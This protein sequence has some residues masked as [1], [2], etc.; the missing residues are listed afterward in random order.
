MP[1]IAIVRK[2]KCSGPVGNFVRNVLHMPSSKR[3]Q[4]ERISQFAEAL[5]C[6]DESSEGNYRP[7]SPPDLF[8]SSR[9]QPSPDS[10]DVILA[11][12]D[13]ALDV[14]HKYYC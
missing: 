13:V 1:A 4:L 2:K 6:V 10:E 11:E 7:Y 14:L 3:I 8:A 9:Q 5:H 12:I